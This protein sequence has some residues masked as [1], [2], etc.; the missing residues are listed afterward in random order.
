MKKIKETI[1]QTIAEEMPPG[2]TVL[3]LGCG[4]GNLLYYLIKNKN[5][6]GLGIDIN[7]KVIIKCIEK[8]LS[9]IQLDLNNLPLDFPDKS[10]D[11]VVL[12]QTIQEVMHPDKIIM[13]MLRIGKQAILGFPNF[14][15][16]GVRFNFLFRGKMPKTDNLP[17]NWYDTPNIHLLTIKDFK[18]FC[19]N[20]K[21]KIKKKIYFKRTLFYKRNQNNQYKKIRFF[22]NMFAEIGVFIINK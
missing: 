1:H 21:I 5:V 19:K 10:F 15:N 3:D 17:Y 6:K 9:V 22:P 16:L 13:E 20:N 18:T 8:G 11:I 7:Y 14:G 4:N 12:N 2:C